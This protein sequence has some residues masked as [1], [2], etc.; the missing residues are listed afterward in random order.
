MSGNIEFSAE[1]QP[2][3]MR[4]SWSIAV[5]SHQSLPVTLHWEIFV[6]IGFAQMCPSFIEWT[7]WFFMT[8]N[9]AL[10]SFFDCLCNSNCFDLLSRLCWHFEVCSK[11]RRGIKTWVPRTSSPYHDIVPTAT[12]PK[13][14]FSTLVKGPSFKGAELY[15]V[16][17][18]E[19]CLSEKC[20]VTHQNWWNVNV[21]K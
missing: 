5:N 16:G 9:W 10:S 7:R 18:S 3:V 8:Q 20:H 12:F 4:V 21:E 2:T 6:Q 13:S 17:L 1:S 11:I 14:T 19:V 15:L